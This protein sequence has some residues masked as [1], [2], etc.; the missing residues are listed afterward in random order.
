MR[1]S[2][3]MELLNQVSEKRQLHWTWLML[4]VKPQLFTTT[5]QDKN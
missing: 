2:E 5:W 1:G 3:T 4:T